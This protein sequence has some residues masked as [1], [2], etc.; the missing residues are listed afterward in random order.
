MSSD[1]ESDWE[2]E[3]ENPAHKSRELDTGFEKSRAQTKPS[4]PISLDILQLQNT[5]SLEPKKQEIQIPLSIDETEIKYPSGK[6]PR[7]DPRAGVS[8]T[9]IQYLRNCDIEKELKRNPE[10]EYAELVKQSG[11]GGG[12]ISPEK[13]IQGSSKIISKI[14]LIIKIV[15]SLDTLLKQTDYIK[16]SQNWSRPLFQS[17]ILNNLKKKDNFKFRDYAFNVKKTLQELNDNNQYCLTKR[18]VSDIISII[19]HKKNKIE[20]LFYTIYKIIIY[21]IYNSIR[22]SMDNAARLI[23]IYDIFEMLG[24]LKLLRMQDTVTLQYI[25]T[26]Y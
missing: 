22:L 2:Q 17:E 3:L 10:L 24:L 11:I 16:F 25:Q 9:A 5:I 21:I 8:G 7:H 4:L 23:N 26:N 14:D 1:S 15:S 18:K 19:T 12:V 20:D 13:P 6:I